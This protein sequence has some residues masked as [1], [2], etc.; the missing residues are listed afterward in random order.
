MNILDQEEIKWK[1]IGLLCPEQ[2]IVGQILD[3]LC[4]KKQAS[5]HFLGW[6]RRYKSFYLRSNN[7]RT[8]EPEEDESANGSVLGVG[9][10]VQNCIGNLLIV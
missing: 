10:T 9:E 2:N 4:D 8:E 7:C 3:Y 1:H 5:A 6:R